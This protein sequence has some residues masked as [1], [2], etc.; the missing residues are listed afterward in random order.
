MIPQPYYAY[1]SLYFKSGIFHLY[2]SYKKASPFYLQPTLVKSSSSAPWN[3]QETVN[4]A[5]PPF[6]LWSA[7]LRCFLYSV[8]SGVSDCEPAILHTL[9]N[10]QRNTVGKLF[11]IAFKNRR[12][13]K[14]IAFKNLKLKCFKLWKLRTQLTQGEQIEIRLSLVGFDQGLPALQNW[15]SFFFFV[16]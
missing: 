14:I 10:L 4:D 16:P 7:W 9:F 5:Q 3:I 6:S 11:W 13:K 12:I 1:L 8:L 2:S 15:L